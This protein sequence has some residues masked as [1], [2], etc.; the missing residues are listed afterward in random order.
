MFV[1][2]FICLSA[3]TF[4]SV[5]LSPHVKRLSGLPYEGLFY[6]PVGFLT[7]SEPEVA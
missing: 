2:L 7:S 6:G 4:I 3:P 5:L 1:C